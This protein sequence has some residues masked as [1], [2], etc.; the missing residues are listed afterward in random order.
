METRALT[1]L[2]GALVGDAYGAQL[3]FLKPRPIPQELMD[4]ADYMELEGLLG[5]VPGQLT[6][7]GELTICLLRSLVLTTGQSASELYHMW[8]AS[9]P[10]DCGN[11]CKNAFGV[12]TAAE[13]LAESATYNIDS[14]ANGALM[15]VSPIGV[16][17]AISGHTM[18]HIANAARADALLSHP[19]VVCQEANAAYVVAIAHLIEFGS[20]GREE[21]LMLALQHCRNEVVRSWITCDDV[22]NVL[23]MTMTRDNI[24]WVK[25]GVMLA[26]HHLRQ[27]TSYEVAIR[28]TCRMG[29]DTDT[30]ACIV[31][32]LIGATC[33]MNDIPPRWLNKVIACS[34]RP[35]WLRPSCVLDLV[36][37]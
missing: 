9:D 11:T 27:G 21:A 33:V 3:E 6:D 12:A 24:G 22:E 15:R 29:G 37:K 17:G 5:L 16:V 26:F 2:Y 1:C 14:Q 20:N 36:R 19:N 34:E 31:G 23:R 35:E 30:N 7:D 18:A 32:G 8:L 25:W 28:E 10:V 4:L 13:Q